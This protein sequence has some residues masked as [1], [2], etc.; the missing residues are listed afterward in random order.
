MNLLVAAGWTSHEQFGQQNLIS[1]TEAYHSCR[2][3]VFFPSMVYIRQLRTN[4]FTS[5]FKSRP[6]DDLISRNVILKLAHHTQCTWNLMNVRANNSYIKTFYSSIS[7]DEKNDGRTRVNTFV[8]HP[9]RAIFSRT[10]A[11]LPQLPFIYFRFD[12]WRVMCAA[13]ANEVCHYCQFG[14]WFFKK[15]KFLSLSLSLGR[16]KIIMGMSTETLQRKRFDLHC[17][18]SFRVDERFQKSIHQSRLVIVLFEPEDSNISTSKNILIDSFSQI[19]EEGL[20]QLKSCSLN[21]G[22]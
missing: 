20:A 1:L 21:D 11:C 19:Q 17:R 6:N 10:G 16:E 9:A 12:F 5:R 13:A 7:Y 22:W 8:V 18:S 14:T 3:S 15:K 4:S 2:S